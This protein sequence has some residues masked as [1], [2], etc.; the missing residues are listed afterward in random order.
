VTEPTHRAFLLSE[1]ALE[2]L[3]Q[4]DRGVFVPEPGELYREVGGN[5]HMVEADFPAIRYEGREDTRLHV[6]DA[7]LNLLPEEDIE[8]FMLGL[9]NKFA[10][11]LLTDETRHSLFLKA[12]LESNSLAAVGRQLHLGSLVVHYK[13]VTHGFRRKT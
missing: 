3:L 4:K 9:K 12:E 5:W 2:D 11:V 13:Q 6:T 1:T 8:S 7:V 10:A